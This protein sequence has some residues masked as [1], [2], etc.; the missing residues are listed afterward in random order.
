MYADI[1][2]KSRTEIDYING[3]IVKQA[4]GLKMDVPKNEMLVEL[5]HMKEQHK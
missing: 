2:K 5:V 3:Y 4:R 1:L